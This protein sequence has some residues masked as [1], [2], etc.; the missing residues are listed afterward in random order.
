M[1][2]AEISPLNATNLSNTL[3]LSDMEVSQDVS[4]ERSPSVKKQM[5]KLRCFSICSTVCG[6]ILIVFAC[7]I[8]Y[9]MNNLILEGAKKSAALT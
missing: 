6:F 4:R 5:N 8:P 9:L 2:N 7:I 1:N 3:A